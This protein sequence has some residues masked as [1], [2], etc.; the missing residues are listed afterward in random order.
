MKNTD[1][2][3]DKGF[4]L[5]EM[6]VTF[7]ILGMLLTVLAP[8]LKVGRDTW[9][10]GRANITL[11]ENLNFAL[12]FISREIRQATGAVKPGNSSKNELISYQVDKVT[13]KETDKRKIIL[14]NGILY[15]NNNGS[16]AP[17]TSSNE[18]FITSAVIN[19][20]T[21][22]FKISLTGEFR[23]N[24]QPISGLTV[25]SQVYKRTGS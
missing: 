12:D 11:Q 9:N 22:P 25:S 5:V 2:K 4:T 21:Q 18:V 8:M 14:K 17:L 1:L 13:S 7:L 6:L 15:F 19:I 20:S 10:S 24:G 23:K 16:V 3:D